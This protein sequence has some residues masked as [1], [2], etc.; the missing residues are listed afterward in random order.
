MHNLRVQLANRKL[1]SSKVQ[2][3]ERMGVPNLLILPGPENYEGDHQHIII[4]IVVNRDD[5]SAE[6]ETPIPAVEVCGMHAWHSRIRWFNCLC[7]T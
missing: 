5:G 2:S 3:W 7:N 4:I 1:Q 6:L